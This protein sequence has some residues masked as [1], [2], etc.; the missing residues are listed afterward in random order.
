MGYWVTTLLGAGLVSLAVV[1]KWIR[2]AP[3]LVD[4][5]CRKESVDGTVDGTMGSG[6]GRVV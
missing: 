1:G 3:L 6:L 5:S 4:E 2:D